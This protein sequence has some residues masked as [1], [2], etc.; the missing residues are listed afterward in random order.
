MGGGAQKR[1]DWG[2][3]RRPTQGH[4]RSCLEH[5]DEAHSNHVV[6]L[7]HCHRQVFERPGWSDLAECVSQAELRLIVSP[8]SF[9]FMVD[10]P[11]PLELSCLV[12]SLHSFA[13]STL[14]LSL[15][16]QFLPLRLV[17]HG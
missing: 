17:P 12:E 11:I 2:H 9:P 14:D 10:S 4:L 6:G 5:R 15:A 3:C 8:P 1:S 13:R 16:A 7:W